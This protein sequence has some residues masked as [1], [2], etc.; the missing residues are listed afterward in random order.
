MKRRYFS[1]VFLLLSAVM[2][3][4]GGIAQ[5]QETTVPA[6]RWVPGVWTDPEWLTVDFHR[7]Q[8]KIENQ[9]ATTTIDM[10]FTNTGDGLAEGTFV[11]PLPDNA[12]VDRLT[13]IIDGEA[14]EAKILSA[15]E[16]RSIYDEIVRQHRDPALL[17]YIG[18]QAIQANV[19]P[20]PPGE[21]R[22]IQ[23]D[24]TQLLPV[25]NG[26]VEYVYPLTTTRFVEQLSLSVEVTGTSPIG[27]VYSPSHQVAVSRETETSFRA[28][29]EATDVV[30]ENDFTLYYGVSTDSI[31]LNLLTYKESSAADGFFL[32][33]VQPPLTVAEEDITPKDVVLVIDQSGS[34]QGEKWTQAQQAARYV[35]EN[36]NPED[37]FNIV[38]FST[39]V[40][41][42]A[43]ALQPASEAAD[44]AAWV[45][46]LY[47]EGGTDIN[48]GLL[49]ALDMVDE[50]TAS[51]LFMTD[52]VP[53]EG[54]IAVERIIANAEAVGKANARVFS[55]GVGDDV[56]TLLLDTMVRSFNGTG[57]Y[58]RPS[59]RIDESM[60][61][62]YN[63]ISAP[64][65]SDVS[66]DF[67]GI[68]AELL[69]PAALSD[70]FAGEQ[71]VMVG[72]YRQGAD[73]VT[74]RLN[75]TVRG[76]ATEF[77][78]PELTFR[79]NAGGDEFIARLWAQRR[80]ADLL[81]TI[82][83]NGESQELVDSVVSLSVRYGIITP[84]TSFLIEEDDILTQQ[85]RTRALEEAEA[86]FSDMRQDIIGSA[87]VDRSAALNDMA[88][89]SAP[90]APALS[91]PQGSG[92]GSGIIAPDG[93]PLEPTTN[94]IQVVGGKTFL[95]IDG[96]WTDTTFEPDTMTTEKVAFLSD[97]YFDLLAAHADIGRYLAL[98]ER[99]IVVIDGTA[100]EVTAE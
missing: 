3:V 34:M 88:M 52:G 41:T 22:R 71:V 1:A 31:S 85:G 54:E 100:Y 23:I 79:D 89:E 35:L 87:A 66:I 63:K 78:Y 95:Q 6:Q 72:R 61:S 53:T 56:N 13:M 76:T 84:Y 18:T 4:F 9:L 86:N 91:A 19:F 57:T 33:L 29:F 69:Y 77:V 48:A 62:L 20:I 30:A 50:R 51:I 90:A 24:Y 98:G 8:V 44:A 2:M 92:S 96:V 65:L 64:V 80:I 82:Q 11:F 39:G 36:L 68:N 43:E 14:F 38:M 58:V 40:R 28:G 93:A 12:A 32:L 46:S 74:V 60:S 55:F 7:V 17:E 47:A 59:Q 81:G 67:G 70:L 16:A 15:E 99:V 75:G 37:R 42:Y 5:A 25:D 83:I 27:T 97:A 10:Q 73:N 45:D 49:K 21:S 94:P 26:L